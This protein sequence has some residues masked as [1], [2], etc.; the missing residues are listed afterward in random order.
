MLKVYD[1]N[2]GQNVD[3]TIFSLYFTVDSVVFDK[4]FFN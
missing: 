2:S 1:E 4:K 3:I